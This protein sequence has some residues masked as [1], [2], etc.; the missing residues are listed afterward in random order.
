MEK[1]EA[2]ARYDRAREAWPGI[3]VTR[4]AFSA[5]LASRNPEH[6]EELYLACACVGGDSAAISTFEARFFSQ[7]APAVRRFGTETFVDDVKQELRQR[8]FVGAGGKPKLVEYSGRGG[9]LQWVRAVA[10]RVALNL[11]HAQHDERFIG[12]GNDDGLFELPLRDDDPEL[13]HM[14]SLYRAEFKK[15]FADGM[16]AL[17]DELRTHLR[18]YYLD[19]LG[20]V[21]IAQLFGSSA[22][23]VSRRLAAGRTE[24][25]ERT[26]AALA[27]RLEVSEVEL[28]SIMRLIESKLSADAL[29]T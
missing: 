29:K 7:V 3:E 22:P 18:L 15:A 23:T 13:A 12:V 25:L 2:D 14:K 28:S 17:S 26:R 4:E 20:V 10:T 21:Q 9:L 16:A 19:G 24:V 27:A 1:S 6:A 8:L 5:W 11:R